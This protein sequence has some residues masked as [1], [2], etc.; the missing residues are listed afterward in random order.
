[1]YVCN[2]E[3]DSVC[4]Y[5]RVQVCMYCM[6]VCMYVCAI[7]YVCMYVCMYLGMDVYACMYVCMYVCSCRGGGGGISQ[8]RILG[9][10]RVF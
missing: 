5:L 10:S 8:N 6:G 3:I 9:F 2:V 7:T 1:M 4:M